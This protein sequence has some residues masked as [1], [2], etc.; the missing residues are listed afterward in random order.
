MT[1]NGIGIDVVCLSRM[2]LHSAPLFRYPVAQDHQLM[3]DHLVPSSNSTVGHHLR[4][5]NAT[6]NGILLSSLPSS[7]VSSMSP[8]LSRVA[9][10][11]FTRE[12]MKWHYGIPHWIDLSYWTADDASKTSTEANDMELQG[13]GIVR[14]KHTK[15]FVPRVRMYEPQMM[16]IGGLAN[17]SIPYIKNTSSRTRRMRGAFPVKQDPVHIEDSLSTISSQGHGPA[18]LLTAHAKQQGDM[19][20][21][22]D[23]YDADVFGPARRS[24][25]R[26]R[27]KHPT[28]S[29][30]QVHTEVKPEIKLPGLGQHKEQQTEESDSNVETKKKSLKA[31]KGLLSL[32]AAPQK[33]DSPRISRSISYALRG[34]GAAPRATAST[35]INIENIQAQGLLGARPGI[36]PKSLSTAGSI[37]SSRTTENSDTQSLGDTGSILPAD[38]DSL[39]LR[40]NPSTPISINAAQQKKTQKIRRDSRSSGAAHLRSRIESNASTITS[41]DVASQSDIPSKRID[42]MSDRESEGSSSDDSDEGFKPG[43]VVQDTIPFIR[44]VNASNPKK[45][46]PNVATWFGRWQHLYPRKPKAATVKW[47]SLCTPASVP[48]TT[49]DFP[50]FDELKADFESNSYVIK[51]KSDYELREI[52]KTRKN[53][54][55][56]MLTLRLAHGYQFSQAR[57]TH[58]V[59]NHDRD[60][61][62][63]HQGLRQSDGNVYMTMGSSLQSLKHEGEESVRVTRYRR[64]P[65]HESDDARRTIEYCPNIRTILSPA[66]KPRIL[67]LTGY[68]EEYPWEAADSYLA[69]PKKR[70]DNAVE[71]LRFWRARFAL[72]PVDPPASA[73]RLAQSSSENEEEIHLLGIRALTQLWQR[74]RYL[75]PQDKISSKPAAMRKNLNPLAIIFETL[76]PSEIVATE[77]D[78]LMSAED[79]GELQP[80]QLLP[81]SELFERETSTLPY[82]AQTMQGDKGIEIK[83]RRWHLRLHY[84]C[85]K[86]EDFTNWLLR[87]FKE[88]EF[89]D[90]DDCVDFG[91]TL[92]EDGLFTHVNGRHNFKDGNY[93]YSIAPDYR[94]HRAESR[95]SWL[96]FPASRRSERSVPATPA[97]ERTNKDL[98]DSSP[99]GRRS[100]TGSVIEKV[101]T[102]EVLSRQTTEKKVSISLSGQI[103]LDVDPRKRSDRT[104]VANLYYDR[105]HNPENCYRFAL[106]WPP[107]TTSALVENALSAW[108]SHVER[109]GLKL[110]EVPIA[111]A[112]KVSENEPFRAPYKITLAVQPPVGPGNGNFTSTSF[113]PL[114]PPSPDRHLFHRALLARHNFVLLDEAAAAFPP[115]VDVR[116]YWGTL[117]YTMIQYIHRSGVILAQIADDGSILLLANRLYNTRPSTTKDLTKKFMSA[118]DQLDRTA[119]RTRAATITHPAMQASGIIGLNAA[120]PSS[121]VPSPLV[122]ARASADVF[123]NRAALTSS[124]FATYIT[125]EQIKDELETFASSA[126]KL[127]AFYREVNNALA[128]ARKGSNSSVLHP[129]QGLDMGTIPEIRLPPSLVARTHVEGLGGKRVSAR[130]GQSASP[131]VKAETADEISEAMKSPMRGATL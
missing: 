89:Q 124:G 103:S 2:P 131:L 66:Y 7:V 48:L 120:A 15:R 5:G 44:N 85:F 9:S 50:G 107:T 34:L 130:E 112:S 59:G 46:D 35:E 101:D 53:L 52:P 81:D 43:S 28:K 4:I 94:A 98:Q 73:W 111:E 18:G 82:L 31:N 106:T 127:E 116:I 75:P 90:R 72:L 47:R 104:E 122:Q 69:D 87:T 42:G 92:M 36:E 117:S 99:T 8:G 97:S 67:K 86:G 62:L 68:S 49:E 80:T 6:R 27:S 51:Q 95:Q 119:S 23:E 110:V 20:R 24:K 83:N 22:M 108:A 74:Q 14:R 65:K 115:N 64:K 125:P 1:N 32:L 71:K 13:G 17:I 100:R 63:L 61:G 30:G 77:L 3:L 84:N 29:I 91:N 21:R 19:I 58:P 57:G 33:A 123:G 16:G 109:Y 128:G 12:Y 40:E 102:E 126:S 70:L 121:P 114:T 96:G 113:S 79:T 88:G 93:F 118:T 25:T 38:D 78:K 37:R 39:Q 54:F 26:D 129:E 60:P 105:L 41:L 76:N 10:S 55:A 11:I 56:D 45:Y